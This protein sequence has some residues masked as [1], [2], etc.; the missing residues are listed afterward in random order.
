MER[1][2]RPVPL[3]FRYDRRRR[4]A[5]CPG[6]I[7]IKKPLGETLLED[8]RVALCRCGES[9][10]KPFCD[11]RHK[12]TNLWDKR[13]LGDDRLMKGPTCDARRLRI[14]PTVNGP[15]LFLRGE[16]ENAG[17]GEGGRS[18]EGRGARGLRGP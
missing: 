9:R 12:Q 2:M 11:N 8:T 6:D 16:V 1:W 13:I 14:I 10:N 3:C 5:L 4:F 17:Y 15:L 7:H 18:K